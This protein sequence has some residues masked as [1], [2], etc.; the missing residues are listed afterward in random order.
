MK[1]NKVLCDICEKE[2]NFNF[3]M[4]IGN[5]QKL[6][7]INYSAFRRSKMYDNQ[8]LDKKELDFCNDCCNKVYKYINKLKNESR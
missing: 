5:F 4:G 2:I 8:E 3:E 6:E 1:I 7:L